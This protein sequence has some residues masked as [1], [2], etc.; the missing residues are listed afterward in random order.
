MYR[1]IFAIC[2]F[3]ITNSYSELGFSVADEINT[4]SSP[5]LYF[6]ELI[7]IE[8]DSKPDFNSSMTNVDKNDRFPQ[9]TNLYKDPS[10]KNFNLLNNTFQYLRPRAPPF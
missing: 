1:F 8:L 5:Q 10:N 7:D 4:N 2:I 9:L 3:F 6:D